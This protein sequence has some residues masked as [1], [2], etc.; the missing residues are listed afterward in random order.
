M[1][2]A[3]NTEQ[4][5]ARRP[6]AVSS[7]SSLDSSA[8]AQQLYQQQQQTSGV[9]ASNLNQ[10]SGMAT[11][12]LDEIPFSTEF[13]HPFMFSEEETSPLMYPAAAPGPVPLMTDS[14]SAASVPN[15]NTVP[16]FLYQLTKMLTDDNREI[17]EWVNGKL[18]S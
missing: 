5:T 8:T 3:D 9:D 18:S 12:A 10:S 11:S 7:T 13:N 4:A 16:E 14:A 17:I 6:V 1:T 2:M 15:P